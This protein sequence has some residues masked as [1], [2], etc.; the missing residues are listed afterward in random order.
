MLRVLCFYKKTARKEQVWNQ[1]ID[2]I[3]YVTYYVLKGVL[4]SFQTVYAM[5][6]NL[7]FSWPL[8]TYKPFL[9]QR[10]G[11]S[12][13]GQSSFKSRILGVAKM[14]QLWC[15]KKELWIW[16]CLLSIGE[17][18]IWNSKINAIIFLNP[19]PGVVFEEHVSYMAIGSACYK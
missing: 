3:L 15:E 8:K 1:S 18:K 2:C 4:E 6:P 9:D 17:L 10:F 13:N 16:I 19:C 7:F 14:L 5:M 11:L 12:G